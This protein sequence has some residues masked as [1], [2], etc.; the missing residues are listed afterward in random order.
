MSGEVRLDTSDLVRG[1]R[2]LTAGLERGGPQTARRAAADTAAAIR[3]H[4][5]QRTGRLAATISAVPSGHG[6]GVAY[7]GGLRYARPVAARTGNVARGIAGQ[8]DRFAAANRRLAET[9]IK[10]L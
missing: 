3:D 6:W 1:V 9:E 10:R 5:P 2:Q 8:P 4:T 7:G